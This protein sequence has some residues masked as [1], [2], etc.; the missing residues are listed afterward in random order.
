MKNEGILKNKFKVKKFKKDVKRDN[1][2]SFGS[3]NHSAINIGSSSH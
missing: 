2:N 1:I 3:N